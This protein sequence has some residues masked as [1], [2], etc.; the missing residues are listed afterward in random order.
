MTLTIII[1]VHT[2]DNI[3]FF[4]F[5]KD[6]HTQTYKLTYIHARSRMYQSINVSKLSIFN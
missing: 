1:V 3:I 4:S 5:T 2:Y 6:T